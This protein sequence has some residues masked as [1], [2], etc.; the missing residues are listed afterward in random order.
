M[1]QWTEPQ[2]NSRGRKK[3]LSSFQSPWNCSI[4]K[5]IIVL[6]SFPE[7]GGGQFLRNIDACLPVC[8]VSSQK[9]VARIYEVVPGILI[10]SQSSLPRL[11]HN[12]TWERGGAFVC[13]LRNCARCGT[14]CDVSSHCNECRVSVGTAVLW[15]V[16]SVTHSAQSYSG[17]TFWVMCVFPVGHFVD[18]SCHSQTFG[19]NVLGSVACSDAELSWKSEYFINIWLCLWL[20]QTHHIASACTGP[21]NKNSC[22][23]IHASS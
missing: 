20:G 11:L 6:D 19:P 16:S 9:A 22:T 10:C 8:T 2:P 17:Y 23:Y 5:H 15:L 4:C 13:N 14:Y 3:L 7:D 1:L 18:V 12:V 21:N